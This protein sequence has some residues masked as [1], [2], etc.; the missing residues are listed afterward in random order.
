MWVALR[1]AASQ[2]LGHEILHK[3]LLQIR[4]DL[5]LRCLCRVRGPEQAVVLMWP[6]VEG[7]CVCVRACLRCPVLYINSPYLTSLGILTKL[8]G[9]VSAALIARQASMRVDVASFWCKALYKEVQEVV[10]RACLP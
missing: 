7:V 6:S 3:D 10:W 4:N 5:D 2:P 9:A 8:P 1:R